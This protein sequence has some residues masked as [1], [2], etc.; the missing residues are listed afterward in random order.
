MYGRIREDL[1]PTPSRIHYQF[2]L[3]DV[4]KVFQGILMIEKQNCTDL[5]TVSKLWL[6][7]SLRVFSDRLINDQG[8]YKSEGV[9]RVYGKHCS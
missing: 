1:L 3:R 8:K 7:E 9:H 4:A 6:H 5:Q 2:N